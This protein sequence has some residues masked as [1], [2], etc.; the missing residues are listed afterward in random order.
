[1]SFDAGAFTKD[2]VRLWKLI[3]IIQE[4]ERTVVRA[5]NRSAQRRTHSDELN[6]RHRRNQLFPV[7]Y[8]SDPAW[9][10]LLD[11]YD[12][13]VNDRR[14]STTGLGLA[15]GVPQTTMLRYVDLLVKDGLAIRVKDPADGR[16][17]FVEL[18]DAGMQRMGMLFTADPVADQHTS[19]TIDQFEQQFSN[20]LISTVNSSTHS[21]PSN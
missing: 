2:N 15:G 17:I 19:D 6:F 12:A 14:I 1:M 3:N 20:L 9:D 16:R 11:L 18:T 4:L 8:F 21:V 5:L 13:K 10:I 7:G